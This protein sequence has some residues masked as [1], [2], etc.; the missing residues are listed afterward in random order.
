MAQ[1]AADHE[2]LL[3]ESGTGTSHDANS[4]S[5]A[6]ASFKSRVSNPSVNQP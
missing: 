2:G 1:V 3:L 6:L 4:P 5:N